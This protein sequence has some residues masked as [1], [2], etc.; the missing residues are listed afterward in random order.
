MPHRNPTTEP[1]HTCH[2]WTE[3]P[4]YKDAFQRWLYQHPE[5]RALEQSFQH[6]ELTV[7]AQEN[8]HEALLY[9]IERDEAAK[10]Y[11]EDW[12]AMKARLKVVFDRECVDLRER[13]EA[14]KFPLV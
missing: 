13:F 12:E 1:E 7:P 4:Q 9:V 3:H 8:P 5:I 10:K 2:P 6:Q 11:K 14:C